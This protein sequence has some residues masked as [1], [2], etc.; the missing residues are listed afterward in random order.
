MHRKTVQTLLLAS[1]F[2]FPVL[3]ALISL[4]GRSIQFAIP[5]FLGIVAYT[6]L[7]ANIIF[8]ARPKFIE[9][10]YSLDKLNRFHA[11]QAIVALLIAMLHGL[12]EQILWGTFFF[13][14]TLFGYLAIVTFLFIA[15]MSVLIMTTWFGRKKAV[16]SL[17]TR[18]KKYPISNYGTMKKVH[19]LNILGVLFVAVHVLTMTFRN[20]GD[21]LTGSILLVYLIVVLAFYVDHKFLRPRRLRKQLYTVTDVRHQ[22]GRTVVVTL[23]PQSGRIPEYKPGQFVFVRIKEDMYP[24]EEHPY[25]LITSPQ[26]PNE[27]KVAIKD[28][29]DYTHRMQELPVGVQATVEGPYGGVW[30]V[31]EKLD[32]PNENLILLAG[33]VGITPMLGIL[34]ELSLKKPP[35]NVMLVWGLNEPGEFAFA[36][37]FDKFKRE[38]PNFTLVPFFANEKGFLDTQ[39]VQALL[40]EHNL[41]FEESQFVLCGPKLFMI[42]VEKAL[43]ESRVQKDSIYYEAFAL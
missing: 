20:Q 23:T 22:P 15:V 8:S 13:S 32:D 24:F 37:E 21:V 2:L 6:W 1:Y 42:A 30:H 39:K 12:W 27:I 28:L 19:N 31:E 18:L 3:I 38:I 9:R 25:S 10:Y 43:M 40:Q 35:N 26:N 29:G 16:R 5:A 4:Q 33:G 11:V 17:K 34:E 41:L 36:E 7:L 14:S